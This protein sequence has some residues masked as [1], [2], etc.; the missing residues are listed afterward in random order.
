MT[1]AIISEISYTDMPGVVASGTGKRRILVH[2]RCED[3]FAASTVNLS[4]YIP[5]LADIE[6]IAYETDANVLEGTASTWSTYTLTIS[7]GC[8][9]AYEGGFICT[10]T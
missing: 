10:I 6:G 5:G 9:G 3:G 7:S 2:L 1:A 8:A 4:T